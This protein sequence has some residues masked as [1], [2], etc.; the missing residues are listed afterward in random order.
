MPEPLLLYITTGAGLVAGSFLV[1]LG[2]AIGYHA[3]RILG[4]RWFGPHRWS[5]N[6]SV[7]H[8]DGRAER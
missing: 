3:G 5:A 7:R 1:G 8:Y 6:A 4:A 2:G